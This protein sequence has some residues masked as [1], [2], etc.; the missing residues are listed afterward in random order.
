[1][2][3][4]GL[5]AA[6]SASLAVANVAWPASASASEY[7]EYFFTGLNEGSS[8]TYT[9]DV[10]NVSDYAAVATQK[11]E[12]FFLIPTLNAEH[13]FQ[14]WS[15]RFT[16]MTDCQ[17]QYSCTHAEM[18]WG[19]NTGLSI[20]MSFD[21]DHLYAT[22]ANL[23]GSYFNCFDEG[24]PYGRT[25][26]QSYGPATFGFSGYGDEVGE[27]RIANNAVPEPATWALMI[28]GF[29]LVGGSLRRRRGYL[30]S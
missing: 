10:K 23:G 25:C 4:L 19:P 15:E 2:R 12:F 14:L 16:D 27:L 20:T 30:A 8:T 22:F 3:K 29:G 28:A 6:V 9:L 11:Y 5:V 24:T 1:L 7:F 18:G 26:G 13:P 17:Q 21:A